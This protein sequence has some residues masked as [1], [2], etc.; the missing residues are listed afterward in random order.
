MRI[1][2][3][4]SSLLFTEDFT[5]HPADS[6]DAATVS[7]ATPSAVYTSWIPIFSNAFGAPRGHVWRMQ[8]ESL[9]TGVSGTTSLITAQAAWTTSPSA[10]DIISSVKIAEL[11]DTTGDNNFVL[12]GTLG[13]GDNDGSYYFHI[14]QGTSGDSSTSAGTNTS[15]YG[16]SWKFLTMPYV[17]FGVATLSDAW[18]AGTIYFHG[19]V[20]Y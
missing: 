12:T 7:S 6:L 1:I 15:R 2:K 16:G 4:P 3:P 11:D 14:F 5:L 9:D 13:N 20:W 18:S 19:Y 10:G 17:R 8:Y